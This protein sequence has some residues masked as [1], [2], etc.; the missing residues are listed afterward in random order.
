MQ[1]LLRSV[2]GK[3]SSL[4]GGIISSDRYFAA[5][6]PMFESHLQKEMITWMSVLDME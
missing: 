6:I 5:R 3:D 1:G 2:T 4:D